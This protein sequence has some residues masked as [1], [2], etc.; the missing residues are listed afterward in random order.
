[1]TLA[2]RWAAWEARHPHSVGVVARIYRG[3][4]ADGFIHA[5]NMAYLSLVTL[6]PFFIVLAATA[7][8]LGRTADGTRAVNAFLREVPPDVA[9]LLEK[10]IADVTTSHSGSLLTVGIIV[11]LWSTSGFI[12]T[13]REVIRR[14]YGYEPHR[15]VF[16]YRLRSIGTVIGGAFLVL[17][18]FLA[19]VL[20]TGAEQAVAYLFPAAPDLIRWVSLGRAV[21]GVLLLVALWLVFWAI[22]PARALRQAPI[23][24]GALVTAIV[25]VGATLLLPAVIGLTGGYGRTYGSLAGVMVA[26]LFFYIVGLGFVLGAQ[27]NAALA[28]PAA[29]ALRPATAAKLETA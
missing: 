19:Q 7:G 4:M 15:S 3:T 11:T 16:A 5:G 17:V 14:A 1:M 29:I 13:M 23:W 6:F 2:E 22:S 20:L 21:P 18:A 26:L 24:P 9:T 8:A 10:P 25:W 27:L 28:K 12:E